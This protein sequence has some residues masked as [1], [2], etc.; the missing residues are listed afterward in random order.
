VPEASAVARWEDRG[1]YRTLGGRRIFTLD[2]AP[3]RAT[4]AVVL[5]LHGF[6]TSSFDFHRVVDRLAEDR[7]VLALDFLGYGFSEKP[8]LAYTMAVQ[9]D[10]AAELVASVGVDT[11]SIVSHDMGDTVAGELLARQLEGAWPVTVRGRVVTN[12]SIYIEMAHLTAGQ[13]LLLGLP[14]ARLGPDMPIDAATV[15]A[16]LAATFSSSSDVPADDLAAMT[17]LVVHH[18]GQQV[19]PRLIRYIEERRQ[20]QARF[21][22]AIEAHPSALSIVWGTHDP[23]ALAA[24]AD[25]LH[26]ARP[27]APLHWLSGVGHYPMVEVPDRFADAITLALAS[28]GV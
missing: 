1:T 16:S 22:G 25:R 13:E 18:D 27:D 21:T 9:A 12:G 19:L 20:N 14:D 4:G 26:A 17:E 28:M 11:L 5:L 7:R 10:L 24:M 3:R 6:P 8:D 23:I 15:S 2:V